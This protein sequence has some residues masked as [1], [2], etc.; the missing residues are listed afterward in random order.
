MYFIMI[1]S[2]QNSNIYKTDWSTFAQADLFV[3][4]Y[5]EKYWS[6]ML[7]LDQENKRLLC[8]GDV[9]MFGKQVYWLGHPKSGAQMILFKFSFFSCIP[10]NIML[11]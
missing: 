2:C 1:L 9:F 3:Q 4:N 5:F 6:D 8:L 11:K 7:Q 10:T